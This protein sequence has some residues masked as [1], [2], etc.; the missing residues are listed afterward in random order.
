M[1]NKELLSE[2]YNFEVIK[3]QRLDDIRILNMEFYGWAVR[4]KES[5]NDFLIT[6]L[7]E[8]AYKCK[9]WALIKGYEIVDMADTTKIYKNK[10]EV[11]NVTNVTLYC[12]DN[13][14]KAC[15]W[16]LKESK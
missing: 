12:L 16:I 11:Y 9:E 7:Y 6:S 5:Y 10:Y 13:F 4:C 1:I 15:E 8:L 3:L 2:V 14:F